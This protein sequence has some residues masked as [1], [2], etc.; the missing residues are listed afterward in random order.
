MVR[1]PSY[2]GL[3]PRSVRA[4]IAAR[5]SSKKRNT[6]PEILLRAAL[7]RRGLRYRKNRCDLPGVPDVVFEN[8]RLIVFVDGDFWHGKNWRERKAKLRRGHN[9]DYWINKIERNMSR[10]LDWNRK[11]RAA[12]WAVL[13]VWESDI[14][15]NIGA[16]VDRVEMAVAQ[17]NTMIS[18]TREK[19][20]ENCS[21]RVPRHPD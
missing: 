12:G 21:L 9:A 8:A 14:Y 17:H 3:Q 2:L 11:L 10:D 18:C 15:K 4:S 19:P 6:K 1:T 5:A 20:N 16:V 13:R 7:W